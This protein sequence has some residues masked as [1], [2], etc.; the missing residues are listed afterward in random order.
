MK[1]GDK[2]RTLLVKYAS[3]R[4]IA[5]AVVKDCREK[6]ASRHGVENGWRAV[7]MITLHNMTGVSLENAQT[8]ISEMS[9]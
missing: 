6:Y 7:A 1:Q 4:K 5:L 9:N 2:I 8:I 3:T